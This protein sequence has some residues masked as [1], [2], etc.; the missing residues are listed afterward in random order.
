MET[1]DLKK[2]QQILKSRERGKIYY[3]NPEN[4]A[5]HAKKMSER[6]FKNKLLLK[7]YKQLLKSK[8]DMEKSD[9]EN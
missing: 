6:Y 8:S 2:T 1:V 3:Q 7:E 9:I 5:K 4:K